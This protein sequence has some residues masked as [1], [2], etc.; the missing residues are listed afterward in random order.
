MKT[1]RV[2]RSGNSQ[3]VRIPKEFQLDDGEVEIRRRGRSLIL[4]PKKKS[5]AA[6]I[7][8]LGRF[9]RDF[10]EHGRRQPPTEDRGRSF[11]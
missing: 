3:A 11:P 5:W 2:F 8:S 6:L 7:N 1:A 9:S 10:M 4:L